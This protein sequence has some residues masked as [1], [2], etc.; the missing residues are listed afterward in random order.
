MP[1]K[2]SISLA[3]ELKSVMQDY[4]TTLN[5]AKSHLRLHNYH[6]RFRE[7]LEEKINKSR[8]K[9]C[10]K[11]S[12]PVQPGLGSFNYFDMFPLLY[13][14]RSHLH[15]LQ[16]PTTLYI[17]SNLQFLIERGESLNFITGPDLTER[18]YSSFPGVSNVP[19]CLFKPNIGKISFFFSLG[20]LQDFYSENKSIPGCYQSFIQP[21]GGCPS[22]LLAHMKKSGLPKAYMI[23][24]VPEPAKRHVKNSLSVQASLQS[25]E[26][27]PLSAYMQ[28]IIH[29][30]K[31]P[32]VI[33]RKNTFEFP[34][35]SLT[36]FAEEETSIVSEN[37]YKFRSF[38]KRA[39]SKEGKEDF[40]THKYLVN[41]RNIKSIS[42][43]Q[44][45][46]EIPEITQ[47]SK[48]L[49]GMISANLKKNEGKEVEEIGLV[50]IRDTDRMWNFLKVKT[51]LYVKTHQYRQ[52][53]MQN[54]SY[55][56]ETQ[57]DK[58]MSKTHAPINLHDITDIEIT[59]E[60]V[61]KPKNVIKIRS[62]SDIK[63][64]SFMRKQKKKESLKPLNISE[65]LDNVVFNYDAMMTKLR[66]KTNNNKS[67]SQKYNARTFWKTLSIQIHKKIIASTLGKFF[68]K[69]SSERFSLI[70]QAMLRVFD[71]DIT[72][73]F[74]QALR[75]VHQGLNIS[76]GDFED[77]KKIFLDSLKDFEI[78]AKDLEI[79]SD[80][81]A[82]LRNVIVQINS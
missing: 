47:M 36:S 45:K 55:F 76:K 42:P 62:L 10:K 38:A 77:Y 35:D 52:V 37:K 61:E 49:F 69:S 6:K 53:K 2:K 48:L 25:D 78:E 4:T 80:N 54:S 32:K 66:F 51:I 64:N 21:I 63:V 44:V 3:D 50:F 1:V 68:S 71:S 23:K 57:F 41:T 9:Q 59:P 72:L 24:N 28:K 46:T 73:K 29:S 31:P 34:D 39:T 33:E 74:K 5:Q 79:I 16:M 19:I 7:Q 18:F 65:S 8:E 22:V 40:Q 15:S 43:C 12:N 11:I 75:Q 56:S 27:S 14:T 20:S 58:R 82:S 70:S 60:I 30:I 67:F 81:F 26:K 17:G 13:Q